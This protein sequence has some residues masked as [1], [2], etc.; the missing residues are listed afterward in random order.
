[1]DIVVVAD[2]ETADIMRGAAQFKGMD[3]FLISDGP[4]QFQGRRITNAY[5]DRYCCENPNY[6]HCLDTI[7]GSIALTAQ[8]GQM[9]LI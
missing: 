7:G 6:L 8:N 2:Q 9:Y 5:I 3:F 1:M 4:G